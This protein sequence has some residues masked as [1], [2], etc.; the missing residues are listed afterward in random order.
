ML[1]TAFVFKLSPC[2]YLPA[3][4]DACDNL[5]FFSPS[6]MRS[7]AFFEGKLTGVCVKE[8]KTCEL[9]AWCPLEDDRNIPKYVNT[10]F[11]QT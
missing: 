6:I 3:L 5:S 10:P 1:K 2:L 9:L 8:T 11:L 4:L 7:C